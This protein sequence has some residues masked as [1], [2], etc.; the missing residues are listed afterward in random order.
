MAGSLDG[1]TVAVLATDGVEQV[2]L[3]RP[4]EALRN[5][6]ATV[7]VV[8]PD[9]AA[10]RG[11][12]QGWN[13]DAKGDALP[14]D[15]TLERADS[16]DYDALVLPGGV[17]NPDHL[18]QDRRAVD[19]V[20]GFVAER[21]PIA[22]ICHGP[23]MLIEAGAVKGKRI[24]SYPSLKT[25]LANAGAHWVDEDVVADRGLITSRGPG[26]LDAFCARL[27]DDLKN[28]PAGRPAA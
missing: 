21:K 10:V 5:A 8:A 16:A 2:E 26:D 17:M 20:R 28:R 18:R 15:E 9:G 24:T 22:A 19:F 6:G 7:R 14:V 27:I 25:D 11:S 13:H 4:V 1:R 3:T 23:W 12:I